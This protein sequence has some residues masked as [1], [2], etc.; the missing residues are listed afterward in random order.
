[1]A[2]L[3]R[4]CGFDGAELHFG[5]GYLGDNFLSPRTNLRTDAYGGSFEKR[6]RFFRNVIMKTRDKVGNEFVLGARLTGEEHMP[7]FH[8]SAAPHKK[9]F[10][11]PR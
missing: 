3:M 2:R 10:Y 9:E 11:L 7:K 8:R 5:H 4:E 1:M 6:T